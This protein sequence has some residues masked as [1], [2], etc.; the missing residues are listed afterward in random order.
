MDFQPLLNEFPQ[1]HIDGQAG[2][3]LWAL[4]GLNAGNRCSGAESAAGLEEAAGGREQLALLRVALA[5]SGGREASSSKKAR[6]DRR[7]GQPAR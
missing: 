7:S 3:H 5:G 1:Q 6:K 2:V 4:T